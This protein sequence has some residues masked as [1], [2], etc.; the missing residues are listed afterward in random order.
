MILKLFL[1][2][3]YVITGNL[4]FVLAF[5]KEMSGR[6]NCIAFFVLYQHT[7]TFFFCE[8]IMEVNTSFGEGLNLLC[9]V[10]SGG[11]SWL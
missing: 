8:C 1:D 5:L 7:S 3:D 9:S 6:L 11:Q 4:D 10:T 2:F